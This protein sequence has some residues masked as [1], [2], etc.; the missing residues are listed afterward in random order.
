MIP[1]GKNDPDSASYRTRLVSAA[2]LGGE[3]PLQ[4]SMEPRHHLGVHC[5]EQA[6]A[7]QDVLFENCFGNAAQAGRAQRTEPNKWSGVLATS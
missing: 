5:R 1:A 6:A 2:L 3:C 7:P 4:P